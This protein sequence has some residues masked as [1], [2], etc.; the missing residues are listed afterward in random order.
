[1]KTPRLFVLLFCSL[2]F[3]VAGCGEEG[4]ID[5]HDA[6]VPCMPL[7][8]AVVCDF[9]A[10]QDGSTMPEPTY[11]QKVLS[12]I[13]DS[14]LPQYS[15]IK[16]FPVTSGKFPHD[17]GAWNYEWD[18]CLRDDMEA[19]IE[20]KKNWRIELHS[21]VDSQW[22]IERDAHARKQPRSCIGNAIIQAGTFLHESPWR[23]D[24]R[25]LVISDFL[26][27]CQVSALDDP[28][29]LEPVLENAKV[30][31]IQLDS[32]NGKPSKKENATSKPHWRKILM[33]MGAD[34]ASILYKIGF[35]E[36]LLQ[37]RHFP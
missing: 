19:Y 14:L 25:L 32:E 33:G 11:L 8:I 21:I 20:K 12:P 4:S 34:S 27:Q 17:I 22:D 5:C 18:H 1:M 35:P 26:E 13:F 16:L 23:W 3:A 10:S 6:E 37:Q 28:S 31:I 15:Q 24:A 36:D 2:A 30:Y 29:T 9:T 7:K